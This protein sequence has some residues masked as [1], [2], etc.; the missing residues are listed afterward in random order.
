MH[1][2]LAPFL[3]VVT[4]EATPS[5][6][7]HVRAAPEIELDAGPER[8]RVDPSGEALRA[9]VPLGV[10]IAHAVGDLA[11]A[12][13]FLDRCHRPPFGLFSPHDC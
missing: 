3:G 1:P 10:A 12:L 11:A 8:V 6:G 5:L 13:A 9:L 7:V 2:G 4:E